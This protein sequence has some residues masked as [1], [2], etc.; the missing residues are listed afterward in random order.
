M[1][2]EDGLNR[3]RG[4]AGHVY[5]LGQESFFTEQEV[6]EWQSRWL[7]VRVCFAHSDVQISTLAELVAWAQRK[8]RCGFTASDL[9]LLRVGFFFMGALHERMSKLRVQFGSTEQEALAFADDWWDVIS[10]VHELHDFFQGAT[11]RDMRV[12]VDVVCQRE[13]GRIRPVLLQCL[14]L[15]QIKESSV[16]NLKLGHKS[17]AL[18]FRTREVIVDIC[19]KT[20]H[21]RRHLVAMRRELDAVYY[22]AELDHAPLPPKDMLL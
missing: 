3:L 7:E 4:L 14:E 9:A 6:L 22:T 19:G 5:E 2:W 1:V 13:T 17:A 16:A 15:M 21:T 11:E 20:A 10:H 8:H 12:L 18:I